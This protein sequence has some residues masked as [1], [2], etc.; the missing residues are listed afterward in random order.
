MCFTSR[1]VTFERSC[2]RQNASGGHALGVGGRSGIGHVEEMAVRMM[3]EES[4]TVGS[5][6]GSQCQ[7]LNPIGYLIGFLDVGV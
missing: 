4:L 7:Y 1:N 5:I 3:V 6:C 2:F